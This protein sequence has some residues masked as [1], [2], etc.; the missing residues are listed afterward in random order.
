MRRGEQILPCEVE[1]VANQ[2][3]DPLVF[4]NNGEQN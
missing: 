1:R 4:C 2:E 3:A